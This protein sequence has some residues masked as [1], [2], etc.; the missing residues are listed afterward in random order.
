L[1]RRPPRL[2]NG[3]KLEQLASETAVN[4]AIRI[5]LALEDSVFAIQG[6]PGSGKTYAGARMI[7]ELVKR[8][9][10][11]G[12]TALSHKVIRKLLDDVVTAAR[13]VEVAE[14]CCL[15]RENE[16]EESDGVAVAMKD[17]EEAWEAL[18][19]GT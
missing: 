6:P 14:V 9:K 19:S 15:H 4:T 18:R 5:A 16:G 10:K 12:V 8:G 13:D 3:E 2:L 17:N 1:L 7:C 11:I